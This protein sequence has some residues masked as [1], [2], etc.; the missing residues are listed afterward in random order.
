[1]YTIRERRMLHQ[2]D[3][4]KSNSKKGLYIRSIKRKKR[5]ACDEKG[6]KHDEYEDTN[7]DTEN[8]LKSLTTL[9]S[10]LTKIQRAK[11]KCLDSLIHLKAAQSH[12]WGLRHWYLE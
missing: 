7:T 3:E 8:T 5:V 11:T 4:F 12:G 2:I 9:E 10:E 1:M 6:E